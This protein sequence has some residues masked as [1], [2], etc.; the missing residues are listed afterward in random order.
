MS[1]MKLIKFYTDIVYIEEINGRI[2]KLLEADSLKMI[3]E[4]G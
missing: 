1:D 4:T 3:L 2:Q